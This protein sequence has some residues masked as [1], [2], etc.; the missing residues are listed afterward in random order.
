MGTAEMVAMAL[1]CAQLS[2]DTTPEYA[3]SAQEHLWKGMDA[4]AKPI[5]GLLLDLAS[6]TVPQTEI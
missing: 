4:S 3:G 2:C 1:A 6:W 5:L